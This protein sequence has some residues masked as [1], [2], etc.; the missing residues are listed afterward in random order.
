VG[1]KE[2]PLSLILCVRRVLRVK[3]LFA[4]DS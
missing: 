1:T 4:V 3:D 2:K